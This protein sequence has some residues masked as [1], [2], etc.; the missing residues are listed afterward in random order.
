MYLSFMAPSQLFFSWD[1]LIKGYPGL[2]GSPLSE[3]LMTK[4]LWAYPV[5]HSRTF[6]TIITIFAYSLSG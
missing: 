4:G 3:H 1:D 5:S 6:S 2:W